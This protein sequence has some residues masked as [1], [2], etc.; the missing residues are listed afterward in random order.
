V[1]WKALQ[2][3]SRDELVASGLYSQQEVD[4]MRTPGRFKASWM[5]EAH[6]LV[7]ALCAEVDGAVVGCIQ[8]YRRADGAGVLEF[9]YVLPSHRNYGYARRL[10]Q[11]AIQAARDHGISTIEVFPLEREPEAVA[12]W[13]HFFKTSPKMTGEV[14]LLGQRWL[15]TGWRLPVVAIVL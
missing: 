14:V 10:V 12:F 4:A 7:E 3:A 9:L 5:A 11:D 1:A 13:T 8:L 15:A 6:Q 2:D